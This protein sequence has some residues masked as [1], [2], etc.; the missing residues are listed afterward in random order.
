MAVDTG[1]YRVSDVEL[2]VPLYQGDLVRI[3][4]SGSRKDKYFGTVTK[5]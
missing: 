1:D 3:L 2:H 5:D 4:L